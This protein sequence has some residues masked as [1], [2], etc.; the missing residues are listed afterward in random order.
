MPKSTISDNVIQ[1]TFGKKE[2]AKGV[3]I[4]TYN[5]DTTQVIMDVA[6]NWKLLSD[7][8]KYDAYCVVAE[9]FANSV[10]CVED[11]DNPR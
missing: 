4:T 2:P 7:E 8:A 6:K 5:E 10:Q 11:I 3:T 9:A 1:H